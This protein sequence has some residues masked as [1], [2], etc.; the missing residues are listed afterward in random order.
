MSRQLNAQFRQVL[1]V[2]KGLSATLGNDFFQSMVRSLAATFDADCVYLGQ[3]AGSPA[4]RL[5][6]LAVSRK[7]RWAENFEQALA[8]TVAGQVALD[9]SFACGK[10]VR[11]RFL[12][13]RWLETMRAEAYVGVR[14]SDSVGQPVGLLAVVSRTQLTNI[15]LVRS[16][17]ETFAP[18]ASSEIERKRAEDIHKENEERYHAFVSTNPDAMWRI[19]FEQPVPLSLSEEEQLEQIYL[20]GY[21]AECNDASARLYGLRSAE[22]LVDFRFNQILPRNDA[23]LVEELRTAIRSGFR[24]TV[25]ETT[26]QDDGGRQVYHRLR[27]LFG[28]VEG[29]GLRRLWGTTRDITDLRRAELAV[30]ASERRFREVLEGVHLP[31]I[32]LDRDGLMTFCNECFLRLASRSREE[33]SERKWLEGIISAEE[34]DKWKAALLRGQEGLNGTRHFEGEIIQREGPPRI[35][36][37]DTTC[38]R[39]EEGEITALAAIGRDLSYQKALE[40]Q[41][42]LS[43]KL[44]S[45]G[46]LAAGIAHDFNDIL[47]VARGHI[48]QLYQEIA[49]S[50]KARASLSAIEHAVM[51]CTALVDQLLSFGRKQHLRPERIDL[52][53]VIT[54]EET[55]IRSLLGAGIEL[56]VKQTSPL[57]LVYADPTQIQRILTY[58]VTNGRDAMPQGGTLSIESSN[59]IVDEDDTIH[60]GVMPGGY[61]RLAVS[62]TG[63]GLTKEV[64][65]HLFEPFF[66]TKET[67]K[68]TG[69]ALATVYGIVTQSGGHVAVQSEPGKGTTFEIL[70]PAAARTRVH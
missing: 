39:H 12:E 60:A 37:W 68:G 24:S 29:G 48:E 46:R 45:V 50:N 42:R 1:Q 9:G 41:I 32:M 26:T 22:Q 34:A 62:D 14:L 65:S 69:L 3:L 16:V 36:L 35:V 13:D 7:R 20:S 43:Q 23:R 38:L 70:L 61:V 58:L 30:V 10:D 54:A 49:E 57:W 67:G 17:L 5:T 8:G 15:Q 33:L 6:T 28:I 53:D 11:R 44:D 51:L 18:R 64:E 56:T 66:T 40:A 55:L 2:A 4:N 52:N 47:T 59:L 21:L 19:E 27:S 31:A 63:V 25:V